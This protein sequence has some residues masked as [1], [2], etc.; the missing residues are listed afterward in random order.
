MRRA[1]RFRTCW[2]RAAFYIDLDTFAPRVRYE[3]DGV[4]GAV[5]DIPFEE[6][7]GTVAMI[8]RWNGGEEIAASPEG[9]A[10]SSDERESPAKV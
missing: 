2:D 10:A 3:S 1:F 8:V 7:E 4:T 5:V 9:P 6:D